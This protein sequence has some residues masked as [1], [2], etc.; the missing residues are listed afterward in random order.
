M[1][2][3]ADHSILYINKRQP[4]LVLIALNFH[5][6]PEW[7]DSQHHNHCGAARETRAEANKRERFQFLM[8]M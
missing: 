2:I 7:F 8:E 3:I 4:I 6:I 1:E 5:D